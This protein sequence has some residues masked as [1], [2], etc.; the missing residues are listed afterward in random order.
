VWC[1]SWNP[2]CLKWRWLGLRGK[3][4]PRLVPGCVFGP[5]LTLQGPLVPPPSPPPPLWWCPLP[6]EESWS[7]PGASVGTRVVG[8]W[9]WTW[10]ARLASASFPLACQWHLSDLANLKALPTFPLNHESRESFGGGEWLSHCV[11]VWGVW[12]VGCGVVMRAPTLGLSV[13]KSAS[14]APAP[15][16]SH[17]LTAC[18]SFRPAPPPSLRSCP[19]A[20]GSGKPRG[21]RPITDYF[22]P[23]PKRQCGG[24]LP[25][26]VEVQAPGAGVRV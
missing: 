2:H 1:G 22:S 17:R 5:P 18:A 13:L 6:P 3:I 15:T 12:G 21:A 23:A 16:Q 8:P 24:D 26:A 4:C 14:N 10:L 20:V 19:L 7:W 11:G 9:R 25:K